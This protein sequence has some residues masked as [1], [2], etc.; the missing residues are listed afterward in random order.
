MPRPASYSTRFYMTSRNRHSDLLLA[1]YCFTAGCTPAGGS[2]SDATSVAIVQQCVGQTENGRARAELGLTVMETFQ[3]YERMFDAAM[4]MFGIADGKAECLSEEFKQQISNAAA[5]AK[6]WD[7]GLAG[8]ER[9]SLAQQLAGRDQAMVDDVARVAFALRPIED[10]A[11]TDIRPEARS[12]LASFGLRAATYKERAL[13][14]MNASDSLGTSAA[15]VA[16]ASQDSIAVSAVADLLRGELKQA[17]GKAVPRVQAKR[18]VELAY[19]IG[20]A[21]EAER[22]YA[23]LLI[24]VLNRDVESFAPPFGIIERPPTEICR[25]LKRVGGP[26]AEH[27]IRGRR[28]AGKWFLLPS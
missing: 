1:L 3:R 25:A 9:L 8:R 20:A 13:K 14:L 12:I 19:A 27:A 24:A 2:P 17:T 4:G 22:P 15:Q 18:I 6:V 26:N 23:N 11:S 5:N 10:G 16:A 21:E 7:Y 28:C